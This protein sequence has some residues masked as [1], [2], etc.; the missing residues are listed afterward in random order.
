MRE[1]S[2]LIPCYNVSEID[3][4]DAFKS[5][6]R[7]TARDKILVYLFDDG[8]TALL[9]YKRLA[10]TYMPSIKF[11]QGNT[12]KNLGVGAARTFC[13]ERVQTKYFLWLDADDELYD[14]NCVEA[15]LNFLN[16]SEGES[17]Q[18]V[19][20]Q[21]VNWGHTDDFYTL[22]GVWGLCGRTSS[23]REKR[24]IFP[25]YQ[26]MEDGCHLSM[27]H[28]YDFRIKML[29]IVSY[30]KKTSHLCGALPS[31]W[32][33][34]RSLLDNYCNLRF[35]LAEA[36]KWADLKD[37]QALG[38]ICNGRMQGK[39]LGTLATCIKYAN[40][41]EQKLLSD[42]QCDEQTTWLLV[43]YYLRK[44][45]ALVPDYLLYEIYTSP[46]IRIPFFSPILTQVILDKICKKEQ[47]YYPYENV[48]ITLED[49]E[50]LVKTFINTKWLSDSVAYPEY[51]FTPQR[52]KHY[53]WYYEKNL[54][55][56]D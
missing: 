5:I 31:F 12:T 30:Y 15:Y 53:P 6:E 54:F 9:D 32:E 10:N 29:P 23:F 51:K 26:Y 55:D 21:L 46:T 8:S 40:E 24:L 52:N 28:V 39:I 44:C 20:G 4:I 16:S 3:L 17:Y 13:L 50:R 43:Q 14:D 37:Q 47:I 27:M 18:G 45:L 36:R 49:L 42:A 22:N 56:F 2:I 7:Q 38:K 33:I 25:N 41:I 35:E 1:C 48:F 34:E 11:T 19:A